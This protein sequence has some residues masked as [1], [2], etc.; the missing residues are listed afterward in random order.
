MSTRPPSSCEWGVPLAAYQM[1]SEELLAAQPREVLE[2]IILRKLTASQIDWHVNAARKLLGL[3]QPKLEVPVTSKLLRAST[4]KKL[5]D[6]GSWASGTFSN[7]MQRLMRSA[8]SELSGAIFCV[9]L[10]DDS[11]AALELLEACGPKHEYPFHSFEQTNRGAFFDHDRRSLLSVHEHPRYNRRDRPAVLT[12][13]EE[14]RDVCL[15]RLSLTEDGDD[16]PGVT[17]SG[18]DRSVTSFVHPALRQ[19][20][21]ARDDARA[22]SPWPEGA[23]ALSDVCWHVDLLGEKSLRKQAVAAAMGAQIAGTFL[24][25]SADRADR[26]DLPSAAA[27]VAASSATSSAVVKLESSVRFLFYPPAIQ[28]HL[29]CWVCRSH[30]LGTD[31]V[32]RICGHWMHSVSLRIAPSTRSLRTPARGA[33][34]VRIHLPQAALKQLY[35][36]MRLMMYSGERDRWVCSWSALRITITPGPDG[37]SE[38]GRVRL[39]LRHKDYWLLRADAD[40]SEL[41]RA[42]VSWV[43]SEPAQAATAAEPAGTASALGGGSGAPAGSSSKDAAGHGGSSGANHK[44]PT[45]DFASAS[46]RKHRRHAYNAADGG[47]LVLLSRCASNGNGAL[48]TRHGATMELFPATPG[49]PAALVLEVSVPTGGRLRAE[50]FELTDMQLW[51]VAD[52][53]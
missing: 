36:V 26:A 53:T 1:S 3:Q 18:G 15:S 5:S 22:P 42:G 49:H 51:S 32:Q 16:G 41:V 8:K 27:A 24:V 4:R 17:F 46:A 47:V 38:A 13:C 30:G 39:E 50:A 44:L 12:F 35:D 31:L 37:G 43:Y 48:S 29:A 25:V 28:C 2:A 23:E 45:L 33:P 14:T 52:Y 10:P 11:V 40:S 19:T 9:Q 7:E 21:V 20:H 6:G 34:D